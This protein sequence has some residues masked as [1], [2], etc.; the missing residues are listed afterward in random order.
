M[1]SSVEI[2]EQRIQVAES[3]MKSA[4]D[5]ANSE[6]KSSAGDKY[7]TGRAMGQLERN[8]NAKQA[9]EARREL[10]SLKKIDVTK[11]HDHVMPGAVVVCPD[12]TFFVG[13]GLGITTIE[14]RK[15]VLLSS[16]APL[17]IAMNHKKAGESFL[18]NGKKVLIT[19]LF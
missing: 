7:E 6:D 13:I 2:L 10:E 5:S 1:A 11:I 16:Q 4:Q 9:A 12:H 19:D 18:F 17:A 14:G 3:A 8:M 15:M